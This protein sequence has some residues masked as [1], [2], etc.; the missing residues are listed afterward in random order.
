[1]SIV[2]R[3][4]ACKKGLKVPDYAAGRH[5]RCPE[6]HASVAIPGDRGSSPSGSAIRRI[7][8]ILGMK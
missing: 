6:C 8:S 2:A 3:C 7:K 4:Q 1:M 5:I